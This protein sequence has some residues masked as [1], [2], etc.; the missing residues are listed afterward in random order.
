M[1]MMSVDTVSLQ[2]DWRPKSSGLVEVSA[3]A[4]SR[5]TFIK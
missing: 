3:V 5:S 1:V 4:R 2:A